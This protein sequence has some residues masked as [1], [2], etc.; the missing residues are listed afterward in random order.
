VKQLICLGSLLFVMFIR[1]LALSV[2][3]IGPGDSLAAPSCRESSSE[4]SASCGEIESRILSSTLRISIQSWVATPDGAGREMMMS[5]GHATV[6]DGRFLVTHNHFDIPLSIRH[7]ADEPEPHSQVYLYDAAGKL[8]HSGPLT[9]F[10]IVAEDTET[11]VLAHKSSGFLESLGFSS[12]QFKSWEG[13][14][15]ES[16]MEVAQVDWD[17]RRAR[18]DCVTVGDIA[19]EDGVPRILLAD[20]A[21]AGA[22]GGGVFWR[23][24]HIA[25][26]WLI[27]EGVGSNG[28]VI[29]DTTAALNSQLVVNALVDGD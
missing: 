1:T 11:L 25:N 9:D 23:G 8:R 10:S 17:G 24:Y 2:N 15:L 16:G 12:A 14:G 13:L 4:P 7:R 5:G 26:N 3:P 27:R 28:D 22:S 19:V 6:K 20:G 21:K 18:V 29:V